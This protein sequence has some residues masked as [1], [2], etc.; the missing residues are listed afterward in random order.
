[1]PLQTKTIKIFSKRVLAGEL[2]PKGFAHIL[3]FCQECG[4]EVSVIELVGEDCELPFPNGKG[5][6]LHRKN[7]ISMEKRSR[8]SEVLSSTGI[9]FLRS[10]E[11]KTL[12]ILRKERVQD[13]KLGLEKFTPY[14][15]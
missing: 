5:F 1:M 13:L 7:L 3:N 8:E 12:K 11:M 4:A 15:H 9:R 6:L 2:S 10:V 14:S